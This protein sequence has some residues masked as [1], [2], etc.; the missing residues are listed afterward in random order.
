MTSSAR[1]VQGESEVVVQQVSVGQPCQRIV[2]SLVPNRLLRTLALRDLN[3]KLLVHLGQVCCT[4]LQLLMGF[5]YSVSRLSAF[6]GHTVEGSC[7]LTKLILCAHFDAVGEVAAGRS[8][9][10]PPPAWQ[11][12]S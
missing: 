12:A 1:L 11:P 9:P 4:L 10:P 7:Q 8:L 5:S 6:L 3:F 2:V